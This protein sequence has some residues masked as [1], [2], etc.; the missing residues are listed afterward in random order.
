MP[1]SYL[2]L[3]ARFLRLGCLAWGGPLPQLAMLRH[4]AVDVWGWLTADRFNRALA[5]YQML[6]GP[7][8][9]EM[10]VY[11]GMTHRGRLGG[12]LAGLGFI[13]PGFVLMMGLAWLYVAVGPVGAT[14]QAALQGA[15]AAVAAL[16]VIAGWRLG[17]ATL[18][19]GWLVALAAMAFGANVAGVHFAIILP[20]AGLIYSLIRW[21][22]TMTAGIVTGVLLAGAAI[23]GAGV[24]TVD[25]PAAVGGGALMPARLEELAASGLRAGLLTFGGAYTALPLLERDAVA[26]GRWMT[27]PQLLDG[28]ALNSVIPA[29]LVTIGVFI[30]FLAGGPLGAVVLGAGIYLPAF[31]FTLLGHGLFERLAGHPALRVFLDGVTAG[32]IGLLAGVA[33]GVLRAQ[34]LVP[35]SAS[36]RPGATVV[37]VA[38]LAALH[39]WRARVGTPVVMLAAAALGVVTWLLGM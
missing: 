27:L 7:E 30:G 12:L 2:R 39:L 36:L 31:A 28:L 10:A 20:A 18:T 9:T 38:A 32:L 13:L 3:F 33:L 16:V 5:V 25:Q 34:L 35:G 17:R 29:P 19:R 21:H 26:V 4:E 22:W 15:Q 23:A 8:A 6:P 14:G 1:I 24:F 11:L 37:F